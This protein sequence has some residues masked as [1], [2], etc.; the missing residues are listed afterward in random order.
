[1]LIYIIKFHDECSGR[2]LLGKINRENGLFSRS[3]K[4]LKLF[5]MKREKKVLSKEKTV[6]PF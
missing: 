1:M 6:P 5:L 2:G 4:P 3:W